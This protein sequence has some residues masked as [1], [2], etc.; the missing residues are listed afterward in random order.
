MNPYQSKLN[1]DLKDFFEDSDWHKR[2]VELVHGYMQGTYYASKQ[3]RV[4]QLKLLDI[5]EL[6][7][8]L[9]VGTAHFRKEELFSS[10]AAILAG[11]LGF[12]S[13][14]A[15]VTTTAELLAVICETDAFDITKDDKYASLYLCSKVPLSDSLIKAIENANYPPPRVAKP[16]TLEHNYSSGY[17]GHN[18][19][20]MLGSGNH[21]QGDLCLDVLNIINSVEYSLDL[22]F[23]SKVEELPVTTP[24][25]PDQIKAWEL[26]TSKSHA[27]YK[28]LA[29]FSKFYLLNKVDKRGRIYAQGYHVNPQ[30][31]SYKKA[32]VNLAKEERIS[33]EVSI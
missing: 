4:D 31:A 28:D 32:M 27:L 22:Q 8:S 1:R 24:E 18:D 30:G 3:S 16:E 12:S 11:K 33:T 7:I 9:L 5:D 6:V 29:K 15:A 25:T 19:S 14:Q 20:L 21:H 17:I 26:F 10:V 2:S 23:L 13:K